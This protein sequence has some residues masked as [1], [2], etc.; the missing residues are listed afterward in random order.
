[1]WFFPALVSAVFYSML[2]V[3]A[4]MSRGLPSSVVT[5]VQFMYGPVILY[6]ASM[7]VD[8]PWGEIWWWAYLTIPFG[9]LPAYAWAMTYSLHRT[10]VTLLQPLFGLS[11]IATLII[12]SGFF[13][14]RVAPLGVFG[15]LFVTGGLLSLYHGRW[16]VWKSRGPWIALV[17][18]FVFGS[19]AAIVAGVLKEFPHIYALSG[20]IITGHLLFCSIPAVP[21]LKKVVWSRRTLLI[22]FFLGVAM[23]GQDLTSLYAFTLG[24]SSY[25]IA[26]KRTSMLLTAVIG[27]VF[28]KERDQSLPRL[29]IA[30][31]LVVAGVVMLTV[32]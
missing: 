9:F 16:G 11:S 25:V 20:I 3:L 7:H 28:L 13:G 6:F 31:G 8:F 29:M 32:G 24:P 19:N 1:M 17:G 4:R 22:F 23:I 10:Q 26:V 14:E 18:A 21:R 27:Y 12:A 2:W 30:S 5:W 15:I